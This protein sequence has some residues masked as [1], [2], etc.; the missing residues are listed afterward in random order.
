MANVLKSMLM[1]SAEMASRNPN[2]DSMHRLLHHHQW[3]DIQDWVGAIGTL[4]DLTDA[5][6]E[7]VAIPREQGPADAECTEGESKA[8]GV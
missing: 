2:L 6:I 3:S 7:Q 8:F 1:T 4:A 5:E